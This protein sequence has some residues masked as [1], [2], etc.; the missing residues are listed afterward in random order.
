[1]PLEGEATMPEKPSAKIF[2]SYA[3]QI[4][5]NIVHPLGAAM[6]FAAACWA[7]IVPRKYAAWALIFI[8]CFISPAQRFAFLTLD[9]D[10]L[11][12]I[13]I[14]LIFR[15]MILGEFTNT[16][17]RLIDFCVV[18][19]AVVIVLCTTMRDGASQSIGAMGSAV[20]TIGV[21]MVGRTLIRDFDD[22]KSL[23]L[24]GAIASVPVMIFFTVEQMTQWNFFSLLGGVPETT[25][26]RDGNL[27]AQG[28]FT[29]P[30]IAGMFWSTFAAMFIGVIM[31]RR[32]NLT[33][34]ICGW[35]GTI[36][37]FVIVLMTNSSTPLAGFMVTIGAW[38]CFP[39]R[40]HLKLIRWVVLSGIAFIHLVHPTGFHA[41]VFT[42]FSFVS[43]STGRHRY[44]LIDGAIDNFADWALI[45]SRTK[46]NRTFN[47]ITCDYVMTAVNGGL[48]ALILELVIIGLAFGAVGRAIKAARNPEEVY[49]AYGVGCAVLTVT[50]MAIAVAVF[51]QAIV[52]FYLTF[53]IAASLGTLEWR[54]DGTRGASRG[55]IVKSAAGQPR[56]GAN[57]R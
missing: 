57:P 16:R 21:Y 2:Q 56:N 13:V 53:G 31:S 23:M 32:R 40:M 14:M 37:S 51:G 29:H 55:R 7:F 1:M 6:F 3:D 39:F 46:Y 10:F 8:A 47:D 20:D 5:T 43:G 17:F 36:C 9:F 44:V 19:M 48:L 34:V 25:F 15:A 49:L 24:G 45:G 50:V 4:G 11:R 33:S 30:I 42:N 22:L 41:F 27:R 54:R 38:C 26:I 35:F 52:P 28:A 18:A 12:A